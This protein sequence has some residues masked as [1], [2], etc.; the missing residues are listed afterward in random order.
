MALIR[1][2]RGRSAAVTAD[3][4]SREFDC[5]GKTCRCAVTRL[6]SRL[7]RKLQMLRRLTGR[8]VTVTSGN[9]CAAHNRQV[10]GAS[11]SNHLNTKGKAADIVVSGF[12]PA[13]IARLAQEIGFGGIGRYDGTAGRFVH[14]DVRSAPYYWHNTTGVDRPVSGHGGQHKKNPWQ[15]GSR[16][17]RRGA[18]GDDVRAV[19]WVLARFGYKCAVDGSYGPETA[20]A[21]REFQREL[22][23]TADGITGPATLTALREVSE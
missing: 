18:A 8:P 11:S 1:Y 15:L 12:S 19:Q 9:R 16:T 23:L 21:V 4:D 5:K 13:Q 7:A 22:L 2:E 17:L 6:D 14:V 20:G 10:G 3:F